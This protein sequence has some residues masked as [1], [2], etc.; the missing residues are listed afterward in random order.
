MVK[1]PGKIVQGC[2]KMAG[3]LHQATLWIKVLGV[4]CLPV[5]LTSSG[6]FRPR[7]AGLHPCPS[8]TP[9]YYSWES[10]LVRSG[11]PFLPP[12]HS[13][14][15]FFTEMQCE[16]YFSSLLAIYTLTPQP[17]ACWLTWE[18]ERL[19][20]SKPEMKIWRFFPSFHE[21]VWLALLSLLFHISMVITSQIRS[22]CHG[23]SG[24][25]VLATTACYL[26]SQMHSVL[27]QLTDV[28]IF[29]TKTRIV[30]PW[31]HYW[32]EIYVSSK[33]SCFH[34][35]ANISFFHE[36]QTAALHILI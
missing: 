29:G 33:S 31:M 8:Q 28:C 13:C 26:L 16:T 12:P 2:H 9:G 24:W 3:L 27:F 20:V 30:F 15:W 6:Q 19:R 36:E 14:R 11:G 5:G 1:R 7:L 35:D 25:E 17:S 21:A 23:F 22:L 4:P 18:L 32:A 34:V 10:L